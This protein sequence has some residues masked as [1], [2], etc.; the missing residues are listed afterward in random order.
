[1]KA[2]DHTAA[3]SDTLFLQKA[4]GVKL[5]KEYAGQGTRYSLVQ[6]YK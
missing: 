5:K 2:P 3:K 6:T 1:M 4:E